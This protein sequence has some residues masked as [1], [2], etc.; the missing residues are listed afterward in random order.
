MGFLAFLP[1]LSWASNRSGSSGRF[2]L[3]VLLHH[4]GLTSAEEVDSMPEAAGIAV[5]AWK[6]RRIRYVHAAQTPEGI[7]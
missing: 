3:S 5:N 6:K 1:K 2:F 4:P 7:R